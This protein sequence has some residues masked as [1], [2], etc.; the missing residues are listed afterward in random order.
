MTNLLYVEFQLLGGDAEHRSH[1]ATGDIYRH[2]EL[3]RAL[4]THNAMAYQALTYKLRNTTI[5]IIKMYFIGTFHAQYAS[6]ST[7]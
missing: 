1:K 6:V 3:L 4:V 5:L 2:D 7:N